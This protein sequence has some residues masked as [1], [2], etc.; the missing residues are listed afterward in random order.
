[1]QNKQKLKKGLILIPVWEKNA[2]IDLS[3]LKKRSM[4]NYNFL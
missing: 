2:R 1:M 4:A 3:Y